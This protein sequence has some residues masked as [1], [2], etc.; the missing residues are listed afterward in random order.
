ME[1][2]RVRVMRIQTQAGVVRARVSAVSLRPA[3]GGT[4][5]A[6]RGEPEARIWMD[7]VVPQV[8]GER[9]GVTRERVRCIA[10]AYLDVE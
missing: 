1:P 9:A 2:M 8:D 7:V 6:R 4:G 5:G 3:C 10:L